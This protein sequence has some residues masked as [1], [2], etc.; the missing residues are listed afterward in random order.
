MSAELAQP[1]SPYPPGGIDPSRS[2]QTL[3]DGG[4][5]GAQ[6]SSG[7]VATPPALRTWHRY[8]ALGDS[9]TE[10]MNDELPDGGLL[11]WAD[12]L[13]GVLA[14]EV[15]DFHYANLAVRGNRVRNVVE[16]QLPRALAL[17]PDLA[18]VAIGV[19]DM[20]RPQFDLPH[21]V[22]GVERVVRSLRGAGVDVVLVS[23]GD[24]RRRSRALG[25][26][27]NR[28]RAYGDHLR[29]L[30]DVY[31]LYLVDYWG[32][33]SF[34]DDRCW[35][36]DRLHLTPVGHDIA[37][38]AGLEAL[39]RGDSSWREP[40]P[41]TPPAASFLVRRARDVRWFARDVTPW[42]TSKVFTRSE[43][44]SCRRPEMEPYA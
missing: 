5:S 33:P 39:G 28:I 3:Q 4:T 26:I 40:L 38:R 35:S 27:A 19:N 34:D 43:V 9:F 2:A 15:P 14:A 7:D 22:V 23:F 44:R 8:V 29:E 12:R 6:S 11:G 32:A 36:N 37:A 30:A 25:A 16:E 31:G 1:Y 20:L 21:C 17:H 18:T 13:A 24:P 41:G 10:G 42:A